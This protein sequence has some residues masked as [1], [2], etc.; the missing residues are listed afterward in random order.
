MAMAGRTYSQTRVTTA[1]WCAA[2]GVLLLILAGLSPADWYPVIP[3]FAGLAL[4]AEAHI[5]TPCENRIAQWRKA[6]ASE[7][8]LPS[9]PAIDSDTVR[10]PL[11]AP[12]GARHRER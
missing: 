6:R 8:Q 1:N 10:S 2:V 7:Q 9:N 5:L 3:L 12:H 11:R 4:I